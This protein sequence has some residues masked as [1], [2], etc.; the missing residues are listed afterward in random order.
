MYGLTKQQSLQTLLI[1]DFHSLM[2][3]IYINKVIKT[4]SIGRKVVISRL[5]IVQTAGAVGKMICS[6]QD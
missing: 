1:Q 5:W 4:G 2:Q 6:Q 3:F